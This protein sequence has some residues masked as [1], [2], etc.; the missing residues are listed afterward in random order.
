LI[1]LR[2]LNDDSSWSL[3]FGNTHVLLDPWLVGDDINIAP[4]FSRQRLSTPSL[5]LE[6]IP[7]VDGI[8]VSHPFSDHCSEQTLLQF[9]KNIPVFAVAAAARRIQRLH[10]FDRVET[11]FSWNK[12][13]DIQT[14]GALEILY[15]T[16]NKLIDATHNA[17]FLR[18][19]ETG[20]SIFYAPHGFVIPDTG[21]LHDHLP[22]YTPTL[23]MTTFR[24]YGLPIWLGGAVNLGSECA[25]ALIKKLNPLAVIRTHDAHKEEHGLV[26]QLAHQWIHPD[27]QAILHANG[28]M[29]NYREAAVG[30]EITIQ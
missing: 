10:H 16:S 23:L 13:Q 2:R 4:W 28:V 11:L 22:D 27:P 5:P 17:F 25:I 6:K 15:F 26:T 29:I 3:R 1:T 12:T 19:T 30:E 18:H 20:E 24:Y 7:A 9:P 21:L 14:F 8:L